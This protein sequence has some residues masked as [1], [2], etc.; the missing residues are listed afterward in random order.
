MKLRT[1]MPALALIPLLAVLAAGCGGR[2]GQV[3][4]V[5]PAERESPQMASLVAEKKL[6]PL[7]ERLPAEGD[8][9]VETMP[10]LGAYGDNLT[11]AFRGRSEQWYYGRMTEEGLFRFNMQGNLEPNVAKGFEVNADSTE[12]TIFL[13]KGMKWSDGEPFTVEDCIFFYEHMI[14]KQSFGSSI[15]GCYYSTNPA[16]GERTLCTM[17][18]ADDYTLRVKFADPSPNFLELVAIDTKW[19]F[20]PAHYHRQILPEFIGQE[21]AEAKAKEMGFSDAAALGRQTGYYYWNNIGLPTLRPWLVSNDVDSDLMV[22]KRNPYYWKVDEEGKQLPYIDELHFVRIADENQKVL[23]AI[24][25]DTDIAWELPF[26][27]ISALKQGESSGGYTLVSWDSTHWSGNGRIELNQSVADPKYRA[28]FQ[29]R[30]FRHALSIAADRQEMAALVSDGW[31]KPAQAGPGENAI[32]YSRS[33]A[34][35]WTEYNPGEARRLLEQECGLVMGRDAYYTFADGSPLTLELISPDRNPDLARAAE[36]LT[37]KYFKNIGIRASFVYRDRTYVDEL[38]QTNG[39]AAS[40]NPDSPM[41]TVNLAL[42]P[43]TVVP[44]RSRFS[45]WYGSYGEW[46]ASNGKSGLEP[47]GDMRKLVDLYRSMQAATTKAEVDRIRGELYKIHE[48]NIWEIGYITPLP[49]LMAVNNDIRNFPEKGIWC[50]EFRTINVAHP[51]TF[52]FASDR[53]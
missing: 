42:R 27:S 26:G 48:E 15:Y 49:W 13:R 12:Y 18:K 20:A 51:H 44:V 53:K 5:N 29:N 9:L 16:T 31:T 1:R 43:D 37:E 30:E 41:N 14:K 47:S 24:A 21:A 6:P 8:A 28:L 7:A 38:L 2:D 33:W 25:G 22:M 4:K 23:M 34:E 50:D 36:L 39:I 52:Y 45:V 46:Y 10:G 17:E 19:M 32:G 40:I 11:I 3:K 35:K